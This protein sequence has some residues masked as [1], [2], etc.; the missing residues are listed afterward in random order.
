MCKE[1]LFRKFA[2]DV[3]VIK[4]LYVSLAAIYW[5][6]NFQTTMF[7]LIFKFNAVNIFQIYNTNTWIF[8]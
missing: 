3:S 5:K 8:R 6:G 2:V 4:M 7:L 1:G